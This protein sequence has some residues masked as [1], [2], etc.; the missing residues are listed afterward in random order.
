MLRGMFGGM[1]GGAPRPAVARAAA[2]AVL[3]AVTVCLSAAGWLCTPAAAQ[4]P[5]SSTTTTAA[6]TTTTAATT[7]TT[8]VPTT[9]TTLAPTTTTRAPRSTTTTTAHPSTTTTT[10]APTTSSSTPWG[11]ILLAVVLALAALLI[12]LLIARNRAQGREA[13]WQRSVRPAVT[14]AELARDLVLSQAEGDDAQRR[15]SVAAQVDDAVYGLERAG[16]SAP[17]ETERALCQRCAD[18]LRGLAFAV[19]ADHLMRSGGE[20]PTGEQLAAADVARRNRRAELNASLEELKAAVNPP[21]S[22]A[23]R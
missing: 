6:T 18:S 23:R 1:F 20:H 14:A 8:A 15:A 12:I 16:D 5:T 9:T 13:S 2:L 22:G 11:W 3:I 10:V 19:E 21:A 7:T 4:S 17:D